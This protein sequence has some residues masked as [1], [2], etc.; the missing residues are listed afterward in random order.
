[1]A[2][3]VLKRDKAWDGER[4]K[5]LDSVP[6]VLERR[7]RYG[8]DSQEESV[9]TNPRAFSEALIGERWLEAARRGQ[10]AE[11]LENVQASVTKG[12]ES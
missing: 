1:M 11:E 3:M 6:T 5:I 9:R 2:R 4:D 8:T 10:V 7:R 12:E